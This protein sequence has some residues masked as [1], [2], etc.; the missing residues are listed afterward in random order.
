MP[1][2]PEVEVVRRKLDGW[3]R[4]ATL[5]GVCADDALIVRPRKKGALAAFGRA[6]EGRTVKA[7]ERKG[8][9]LRLL[10]DD[11]TR[12]FAHLG[13]TGD[14]AE[15]EGDGDPPRF[16]R[17]SFTATRRGKARRV[18]YVDPRRLGHLEVAAE[19]LRGWKSLGPDAHADGVDPATLAAAIARRKSQ[20]IKEL[21]LD[22]TVL[23]GV[24][25]IYAAESLWRARIDPRAK[26]A[27]LSKARLSALAE[28]IGWAFARAFAH[29]EGGGKR[30]SE[31]GGKAEEQPFVV[32]G[33]KGQPCRRCKAPLAHVVLGGRTTTY[34]RRC[35]TR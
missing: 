3:L 31:A 16:T 6:L 35:Q 26:A 32:Y 20:T 5:G 28:A 2:L 21:L 33:R 30:Y 12:L 7:V 8:K 34:C 11:G 24:G 1:E 15:I 4:G 18:A 25:N 19:D 13:M 14:F 23:A 22:Q 10:L 9:W 29:L 27:S 17:A